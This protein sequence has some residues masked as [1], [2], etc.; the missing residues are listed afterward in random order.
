[1]RAETLSKVA[2][3]SRAHIRAEED[4]LFPLL[5]Q[6][7]PDGEIREVKLAERARRGTG[8]SM[9]ALG[10]PRTGSGRAST[11]D[12]ENGPQDE[13]EVVPVPVVVDLVDV[14]GLG[15]Q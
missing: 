5:E 9:G 6:L 4:E 8:G 15:E 2:E 13:P 10:S 3:L 1:M 11:S 7:V 14:H 12:E